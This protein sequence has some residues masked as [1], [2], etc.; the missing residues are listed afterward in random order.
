MTAINEWALG[1]AEQVEDQIAHGFSWF[2]LVLPEHFGRRFG[3]SKAQ[4][5]HILNRA[6]ERGAIEKVRLTS[7]GHDAASAGAHFGYRPKVDS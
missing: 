5:R 3:Y 1:V 7:L 6:A 2:G 4:A